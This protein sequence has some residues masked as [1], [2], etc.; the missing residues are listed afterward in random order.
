MRISKHIIDEVLSL[1]K[2]EQRVLLV[3][4]LEYPIVKGMFLVGPT[5]YTL[6][7]LKH[8]TD[9]EIQLCLNQLAYVGIAEA[10]RQGLI[11]EL[12]GLDFKALQKENILITESTKRFRKLIPTDRE[13][14]GELVVERIKTFGDVLIGLTEF[15]F[16]NR[17]CF[18][19]LE[20]AI[21]KS[22]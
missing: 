19:N 13:I 1:Y 3:A 16:E 17:G 14:Q 2:P 18:G 4:D 6:F 8:A 10:M 9:I 20:F 22:L 7:P 21:K 5:Y 11:S 12:R 15:Q